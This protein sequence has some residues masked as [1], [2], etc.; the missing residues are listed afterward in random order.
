MPSCHR[1]DGRREQHCRKTGRTSSITSPPRL[2]PPR[3]AAL[4]RLYGNAD[5]TPEPRRHCWQR[6]LDEG[7]PAL[8]ALVPKAKQALAEAMVVAV[9]DDGAGTA[10]EDELLCAACSL[11]HAPTRV[12]GLIQGAPTLSVSVDALPCGHVRIVW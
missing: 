4:T 11:I 2:P 12:A 7:W 3:F 6:P 5:S 8:D 1:G 10:S 9:L